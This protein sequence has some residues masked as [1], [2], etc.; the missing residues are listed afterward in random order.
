[1]SL[2][3][4]QVYEYNF[5]LYSIEI[6]EVNKDDVILVG[7]CYDKVNYQKTLL[8]IITKQTIIDNNLDSEW[9]LE[10]DIYKVIQYCNDIYK[11]H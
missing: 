3:R 2:E 10:Y 9:G 11:K 6:E 4:K 8:A 5:N 1:M 7:Y